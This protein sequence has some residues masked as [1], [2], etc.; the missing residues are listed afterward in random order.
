MKI[1]LEAF[2]IIFGR[3]KFMVLERGVILTQPFVVNTLTQ[4]LDTCTKSPMPIFSTSLIFLFLHFNYVFN[5]SSVF[6]VLAP[7]DIFR[8]GSVK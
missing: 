2:G 7:N 3:Y 6:W 1:M 4:A 8:L 5:L